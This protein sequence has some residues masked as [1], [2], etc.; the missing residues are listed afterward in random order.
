[1]GVQMHRNIQIKKQGQGGPSSDASLCVSA[2]SERRFSRVPNL[3]LKN[4]KN[5]KTGIFL[6]SYSDT[7]D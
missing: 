7:F 1:M 6:I 2:R 4:K 3:K 5:L